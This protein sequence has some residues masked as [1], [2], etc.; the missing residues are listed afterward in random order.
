[1]RSTLTQ[2]SKTDRDHSIKKHLEGIY[3]RKTLQSIHS[4]KKCF[5]YDTGPLNGWVKFNPCAFLRSFIPSLF[6]KHE[7]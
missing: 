6:D 3:D 5:L 1:M 7:F 2:G 4:Y